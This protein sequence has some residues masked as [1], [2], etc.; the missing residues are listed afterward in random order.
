MALPEL[1]KRRLKASFFVCAG[2][3]GIKN[4]LDGS[5]IRDLLGAGMNIG[6]HGMDHQ[7]W[8]TLNSGSLEVEIVEARKKI[9]DISRSPV[10]IVAIPFGSYDRRV[11]RRLKPES[12]DCIYT[13]DRGRARLTAKIKPRETLDAAMQD[14]DIL[15]ELLTKP[16]VKTRIKQALLQFYKRC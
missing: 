11:L 15:S 9:E 7:D 10:R 6:S 16:P 12:W 2:R 3:I 5:M 4:Y 14:R 8:R 13:S 1:A